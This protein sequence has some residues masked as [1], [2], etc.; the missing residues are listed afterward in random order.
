MMIASD[1]SHMSSYAVYLLLAFIAQGTESHA[2][3]TLLLGL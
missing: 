1:V 3:S 2:S